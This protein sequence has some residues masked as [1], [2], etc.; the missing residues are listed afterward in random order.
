MIEK[1]CNPLSR[2]SPPGKP[3]GYDYKS[4]YCKCYDYDHVIYVTVPFCLLCY[5]FVPA[6]KSSPLWGEDLDEGI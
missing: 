6:Y 2:F 5:Q 4:D 3:A 1:D